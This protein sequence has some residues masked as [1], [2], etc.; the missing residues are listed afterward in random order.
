MEFNFNIEK[1]LKGVTKEGV[2]FL[3]GLDRNK[4]T[5]EEINNLYHLLDKVGELSAIVII[6]F[7]FYVLFSH[8]NYLQQ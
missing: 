4:Y 3:S 1:T 8:K 2:G 6:F 7:N 5:H